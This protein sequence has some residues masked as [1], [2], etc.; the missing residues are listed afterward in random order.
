[1]ARSLNLLLLTPGGAVFEGA[2]ASLVA[3]AWDGR[4]G[5]LPDHA[6]FLTLLGEGPL[7]VRG[8][9]GDV[10]E[11]KISGGVMKVEKNEVTVLADRVLQGPDD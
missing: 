4:V 1:M 2:V 11:F 10:R 3:P 7:A 9:S 8:G 6:P 5:V